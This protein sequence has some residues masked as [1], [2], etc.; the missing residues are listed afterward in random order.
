MNARIIA[1][2]LT[3]LLLFP[4]AARA[5]QQNLQFGG[6]SY[7]AG[8]LLSVTQPTAHDAFLAGR[9]V[10]LSAP[11]ADTAHLAGFNVVSTTD[12]GGSV[13]AVGYSVSIG[14]TVKGDVT[15]AGNSVSLNTTAPLPGSARLLGQTIRVDS[16]VDGAMLIL[17]QNAVLNQ[18]VK[19]DFNFFG[20]SLTFG[21][22]ARI[23]GQVLIH[24]PRPITVP[25]SVASQDRVVYT[26]MK[27]SPA[28]TDVAQNAV[29]TVTKGIWLGLWGAALWSLLMVVVGALFIAFAPRLVAKYE[30]LSARR[31]MRRIG[32]GILAFAAII[33]LVP[34]VALTL[35]G[36]L[37]V[38]VLLIVAAIGWA[39][40]YL[41]GAYL[42]GYQL[43]SRMT[44]IDSVL[45]RIG[46]LAVSLAIAGLLSMIPFIGWLITLLLVVFG[47]GIITALIM[48]RWNDGDH[49]VPPMVPAGS[50]A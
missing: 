10:T 3:G 1:W 23:D 17:G 4:A 47:Y 35:V 30:A 7:A 45:K 43:G 24:A 34:V 8:D 6:D 2:A 18:P 12:I 46:V 50:P 5:D 21:P 33:G 27:S 40:A 25:A 44:R 42:V 26:E 11:V 49:A 37:V 48:T 19:G 20:E 15:A 39:L 13:Y 28:P 22:S 29:A 36:L 38:P 14:G 41:T 31:P 16:E 9:D 32:L